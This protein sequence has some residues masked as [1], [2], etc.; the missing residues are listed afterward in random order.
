MA[1]Q[2]PRIVAYPE[3]ARIL[4]RQLGVSICLAIRWALLQMVPFLLKAYFKAGNLYSLIA[5]MAGPSMFL[6]SAFWA[7]L[8][9]RTPLK[10]Y[11]YIIWLVGVLP[12][13][14]IGLSP[15]ATVAV[16][17]LI[18]ASFASPGMI[19]AGGD[20]LRACYSPTV[21]GRVWAA[22][23]VASLVTTG[24]VAYATGAWLDRNPDAFRI[25]MPAAALLQ[26]AVVALLASIA[27]QPL[28][29]ERQPAS[30]PDK[31]LIGTARRIIDMLA[32]LV[33]DRQFLRFE[34]SFMLYG[35]GWMICFALLP[36][37][38]YDKLHLTYGQFANSTQVA[39]PLTTV[40][41]TP[42][43]GYLVDR[44]GAIRTAAA[45]FAWMAIYPVAL[46]LAAGPWSLTLATVLYAVGMSAVNVIWMVGPITLAPRAGDASQYAAV[47][48]TLVG[49]RAIL[50]QPLGMGLYELTGS[51]ALPLLVASAG[52]VAGAYGMW[53]L[54]QT[55][56][57]R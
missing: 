50:F 52:F 44:V 26:L 10:R 1:V 56:R 24:L 29:M 16:A 42:V 4:R 48:A 11:A 15:T 7:D 45:A 47:H 14:G 34:V 28:F 38:A 25:Y 2:I 54:Q 3:S 27:K 19:P 20:I 41:A 53:S 30:E 13:A 39:L 40:F 21:R 49:V 5:T 43:M 18:V 36:P 57:G 32:L 55:Q 12:L 23:S 6:L 8:Y 9:R 46:M 33:R 35:A 51:F 37:L 31:P 22:L 17:F